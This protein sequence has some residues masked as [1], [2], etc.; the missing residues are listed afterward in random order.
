MHRTNHMTMDIIG[1]SRLSDYDLESG[2]INNDGSKPPASE[3]RKELKKY[4]N[5]G[6][7][8]LPVCLN[9]DKNGNCKGHNEP[10]FSFYKI[11]STLK[12]HRSNLSKSHE[13][14]AS[15]L[16][17]KDKD[18]YYDIENM[19]RPPTVSELVKISLSLDI[20]IN[21]LLGLRGKKYT[22]SIHN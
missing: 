12:Y 21:D 3:I 5:L 11:S 8:V 17:L 20:S 16:D 7:S 22:G 14:M 15:F 18:S 19:N 2:V 1:A 10:H 4:E 6:F 13:E 9:Y